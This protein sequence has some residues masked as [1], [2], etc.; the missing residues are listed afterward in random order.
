MNNVANMGGTDRMIRVIAGLALMLCA[1]TGK[2]GTW[3][4]LG[5]I[6]FSTGLLKFCPFYSL[7]GINTCQAVENPEETDER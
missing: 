5:V 6:P 3:G 1:A 2:L 7:F 4:W